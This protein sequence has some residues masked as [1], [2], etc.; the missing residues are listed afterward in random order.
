MSI[1]LS[2]AWHLIAYIL[3]G[4]GAIGETLPLGGGEL[5]LKVGGRRKGNKAA[6]K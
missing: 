5:D 3:I 1:E 6:Q 2:I 4:V